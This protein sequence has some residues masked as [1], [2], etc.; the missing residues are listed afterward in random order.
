MICNSC[1]VGLDSSTKFCPQCGAP[2]SGAIAPDTLAGASAQMQ[3]HR[4]ERKIIAG[5]FFLAAAV[6]VII[7]IVDVA[8]SP[9]KEKASSSAATS[10]IANPPDSDIAA[11]PPA[12]SKPQAPPTSGLTIH[13][14]DLLK[15][16]FQSRGKLVA[17]N[18]NS[19]PV[20][21]NGAVIQYSGPMDPRMG[22]RLGLMALRLERMADE[23]VA[24]Y[25]IMGIEAGSSSGQT[26]GQMAVELPEGTT[27]L[28]F[29]RAWM[30]EPLEPLK[31]TNYLGAEI[32]IP[33]VR[34]WRYVGG[35]AEPTDGQRQAIGPGNGF[36]YTKYPHG[37]MVD[38]LCSVG[39]QAGTDNFCY[40]FN[41]QPWIKRRVL[42]I[43]GDQSEA[44]KTDSG[45][46]GAGNL[47]ISWDSEQRVVFTGFRPHDSMSASAYFIVAPTTQVVDIIWQ[48][49]DDIAYLGPDANVLKNAH[50]YEW[51]KQIGF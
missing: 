44:L 23:N 3:S 22:T 12:V 20:L 29:D 17:L 40:P 24:L 36:R 45:A 26:L 10:P 38:K 51:L 7:F 39:Q 25:N 21:Y 47:V 34:F 8:A 9:N 11:P 6:L 14:Y 43:V 2:V 48:R 50:T 42:D 18:L 28:K 19:L 49:G 30:V 13:P 27:E 31:G 16:P 15:N 37:Y 46:S 33:S 41:W 5:L 35:E 32:Q 4:S 1:G